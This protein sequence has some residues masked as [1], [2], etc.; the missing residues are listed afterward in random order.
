GRSAAANLSTVSSGDPH[1]RLLSGVASGCCATWQR[2][3]L[4]LLI[5]NLRAV[6]F[7]CRALAASSSI[8]TTHGDKPLAHIR[9][10][11]DL[12][13]YNNPSLQLTRP[14]WSPCT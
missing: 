5:A 3:V 4:L 2:T 1:V 10:G 6:L 13:P 9:D 11:L 12:H 14:C 8:Y 7:S